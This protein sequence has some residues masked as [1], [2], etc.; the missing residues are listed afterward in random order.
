MFTKLIFQTCWKL[1]CNINIKPLH[2]FIFT[3][4]LVDICFVVAT[5]SEEFEVLPSIFFPLKPQF[6]LH[7]PPEPHSRCA[8]DFRLSVSMCGNTWWYREFNEAFLKGALLNYCKCCVWIRSQLP[9]RWW[10]VGG[11]ED[12]HY[13]WDNYYVKWLKS[14]FEGVPRPGFLKDRWLYSQQYVAATSVL[15]FFVFF[16]Y[17]VI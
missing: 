8:A 14:P 13:L 6:S 10:G 2:M 3:L 5:S 11:E 7:S 15:I 17:K 1:N 12:L 4:F 9:W 16:K